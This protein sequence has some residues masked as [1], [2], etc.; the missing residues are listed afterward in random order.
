MQENM[1]DVF[2]K[3]DSKILVTAGTT[4]LALASLFII[5]QLTVNKI[6]AVAKAVDN[7][8]EQTKDNDRKLDETLLAVQKAMQ[9]NTQA[10]RDLQVLIR[11]NR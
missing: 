2:N 10:I 11:T 1:T 5:Y 4:V 9:E 6:D 3:F 7:Q 8:S